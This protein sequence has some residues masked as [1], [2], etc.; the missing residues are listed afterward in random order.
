MKKTKR[1]MLIS[2]VIAVAAGVS[3]CSNVS[4]TP[5]KIELPNFSAATVLEGANGKIDLY[6][7]LDGNM[8]KNST[9]DAISDVTYNLKYPSYIYTIKKGNG[10]SLVNNEL[11]IMSSEKEIT[12]NNFYCADDIELSPNGEK[13]AYRSFAKDDI[14]SAEGMKLYDIKNGKQIEMDTKVLISGNV[15]SWLSSNEILYYGLI[16][17]KQGSSKI[18]RY[19]IETKSEEVY[20]DKLGGYVTNFTACGDDVL[21]IQKS[22][23]SSS[24]IF[25]EK[26]SGK[27]I[28]I[29]DKIDDIYKTQFNAKTSEVL[30]LGNSK[31]ENRTKLYR[32]SLKDHSIKSVT[33]DFPKF[34]DKN[35]G[36]AT[37]ENGNFYFCGGD[38]ADS[39]GK[40]DVYMFKSIDG[41]IN[42]VSNHQGD[43]YLTGSK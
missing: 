28:S 27:Y 22:G 21:F 34:I 7:I 3:S 23:D 5:V 15:Y 11:K 35:S 29:D 26:S 41:S 18:Y 9:L 36:I 4:K 2:L 14:N 13:L 1:L 8:S 32:F 40:L 25:Y 42:L 37:D 43:Y 12:L 30:I 16:P 6:K 33:Y 24:M 10:N 39:Q 20:V 31:I 19:N 38:S 17:G